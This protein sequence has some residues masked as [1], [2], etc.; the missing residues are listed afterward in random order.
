MNRRWE[1]RGFS[2]TVRLRIVFAAVIVLMLFGSLLSFWHFRNVS[3]YANRTNRAERRLSSVLRLNNQLLG[4][5]SQLHRVADKQSPAEFE[6]ESSRLLRAFKAQSQGTVVALEEISH[7]D[8]RY[9]VLVGSILGLLDS[10]PRRIG[11]LR[12]L[13]H[14]NDW[15]ALH[16]RL[17]NQADQTDDVVDA[18]M[19]RL[20][21]DLGE[22]RQRLTQDLT[23]AQD[24]AVSTLVIT[25]ALSLAIAILLGTAV[26]HS[27][28]DPLANLDRGARALAAGDFSHR[29]PA[30][31]HDELTEI[32]H[33]FNRM[34]SEIDRLFAEVRR[35]HTKAESAQAALE[36][37]AR[38]LARANADLQQFAYSASHDL[39]EPLRIINLYS[40]M[41]QRSLGRGA[42]A[43]ADECIE[44][45]SRAAT[46][47]QQLIAGLLAYTRAGDVDRE[48]DRPADLNEVLAR[49][50]S[51]L[52][53]Q[54]RDQR[55]TI[56]A[57]SLPR[58]KA[59]DI[60]IQQL[61]QNLIGN[62][63]KYRYDGRYPAIE[64]RAQRQGDFW[65]V[66]VQDNGI[67]IEPQYLK[68]VFGIFK[69]LH[70][71]KYAGT[72]IGLAICQRIV[73]GYGGKIWV[74][75]EPG[76]SS[77]FLFTLPAA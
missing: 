69:R 63:I 77:T 53:V 7:D 62:A 44:F 4:L 6:A 12:E 31:G 8:S 41:L 47:M 57:A 33:A 20:D 2:I 19:T 42:N 59:H 32:A 18:L 76:R 24:R 16:A 28:K 74:E 30:E 75:S 71:Q 58:V 35:E 29:L 14:A 38:E 45:L 73:E 49:V 5:M 3:E 17:L 70:G 34:A 48:V 52:Q 22:A 1:M 66:S 40:Q 36:E 26:T 61:L 68:H 11:A 10:L 60:H 54:I 50:L 46:Q 72:G 67:G 13:A 43:N 23:G 37:R 56:T 65:E 55:C 9:T 39:Q 64:I 25:A 21:G 51:M 15:T 27:I